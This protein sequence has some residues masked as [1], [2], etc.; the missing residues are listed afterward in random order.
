SAGGRQARRTAIASLWSSASRATRSPGA[1]RRPSSTFTARGLR[2]SSTTGGPEV[3]RWEDADV[4]E[5][6]AR[7]RHTARRVNFIDTGHRSGLYPI[8]L[9]SGLGSEAAGLVEAVGPGVTVVRPVDRVAYAGGRPG[10]YARA[11]VL[12]VD[13]LVPIPNGV[14]D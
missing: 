8:P 14:T 10:S 7:V 6:Q 1:T 13:R 9:P 4:G 3:L 12:P 2:E 5:G 11:T